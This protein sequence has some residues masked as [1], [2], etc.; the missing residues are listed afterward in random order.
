MKDLPVNTALIII[1]VQKGFD[2]PTWGKRNHPHAE[3]RMA[4]LLKAWR[5]QNRPVI[6]VQHLSRNQ[7]S[8]LW[9]GQSGCEIKNIVKPAEN[10]P[11]FQK[12][13]NSAFIGTE[14]ETYLKENQIHTVVIVGLTTD[15]CVST[16]TRMAGNLGF[17]TYIVE[18]ATVVS[19]EELIHS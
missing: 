19:T 10:E 13:V 18:D 9:P 8:P 2:D 14:L 11:I 17:Q 7:N 15:H 4:D 1:D 6:H 16:T 12:Q 3:E 5:N